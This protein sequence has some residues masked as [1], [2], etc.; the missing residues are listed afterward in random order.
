DGP[1]RDALGQILLARGRSEMANS[2]TTQPAA[3]TL[4]A[5]DSFRKAVELDPLDA[6]AHQNLALALSDAWRFEE[7]EREFDEALR[8]RPSFPEAYVNLGNMAALRG[9]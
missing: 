8:L 4:E 1:A 6:G 9:R 3:A 7:A 2:A 5:I